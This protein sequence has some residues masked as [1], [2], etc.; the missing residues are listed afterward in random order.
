MVGE[1]ANLPRGAVANFKAVAALRDEIV[2]L[3]DADADSVLDPL[4]DRIFR[5]AV[6]R[7]PLEMKAHVCG[8]AV[9][10]PVAGWKIPENSVPNALSLGFDVDPLGHGQIALAL[11]HDIADERND[12]LGCDGGRQPGE[13]QR[14]ERREAREGLHAPPFWNA[15][16]GASASA[17]CS[18]SKN[19]SSVKPNLSAMI[20]SGKERMLVLRLR[21]APL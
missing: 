12:A 6:A 2:G 10:K 13:Q 19:G 21:T 5:N 18:S 20:R 4:E 1:N 15:T 7:H 8:C 16:W 14:Q 9:G 3:A 17:R 11:D